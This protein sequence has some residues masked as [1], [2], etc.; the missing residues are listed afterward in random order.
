MILSFPGF[1]F[2]SFFHFFVIIFSFH[3]FIVLFFQVIDIEYNLDLVNQK[4][5]LFWQ[6]LF[7]YCMVLVGIVVVV[8]N[9][10]GLLF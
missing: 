4:M 2:I 1:L 8:F 10:K 9:T 3:I 5:Q 7:G 6:C